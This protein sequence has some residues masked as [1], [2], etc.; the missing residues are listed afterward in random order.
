MQTAT[1]LYEEK[2]IQLA[3]R[4]VKVLTY[5]LG[6]EFVCIISNLDPGA[7][8][9]RAKAETQ[10]EAIRL[11]IEN[12]QERLRASQSSETVPLVLN[13]GSDLALLEYE[14]PNGVQSFS[15]DDFRS[16]KHDQRAE[17][18]L[19]GML[20]FFDSSGKV[21]NSGEAIRILLALG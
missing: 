15:P 13:S 6:R 8:I 18:F 16:I 4:N 21:V 14:S 2:V 1:D 3:D 12:A 20:R 17:M 7:T 19:S 9:C 10:E 11:T 5:S